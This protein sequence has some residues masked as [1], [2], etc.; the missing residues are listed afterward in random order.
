MDQIVRSETFERA[1]AK[2]VEEAKTY[3]ADLKEKLARVEEAL[4]RMA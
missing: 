4:S 1:P 2:V 3:L